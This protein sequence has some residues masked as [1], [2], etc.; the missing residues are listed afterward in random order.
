M[1]H[2]L[3][4]EELS[5]LSFPLVQISSPTIIPL[6]REKHIYRHSHLSF[7]YK[8]N[9]A[10]S[11]AQLNNTHNQRF[12][13]PSS[14]HPHRQAK[15]STMSSRRTRRSQAP[16]PPPPPRHRF[17]I[18]GHCGEG[19]MSIRFNSFCLRSSCGRRKDYYATE[20]S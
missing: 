18:C 13:L 15:S 16:P 10:S 1:Q 3:Y 7:S 12:C 19:G 17:W 14:S 20:Y 8:S 5:T 9:T 6:S 2:V 11:Y 4:K